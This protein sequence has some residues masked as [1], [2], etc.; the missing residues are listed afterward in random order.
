MMNTVRS[1]VIVKDEN[2]LGPDKSLESVIDN[3]LR[4]KK[5][6]CLLVKGGQ[7]ELQSMETYN[8][9]YASI[10][11]NEVA[12]KADTMM[13][14]AERAVKIQPHLSWVLLMEIEPR[15]TNGHP[16]NMRSDLARHFNYDLKKLLNKISFQ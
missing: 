8:V 3:E 4:K 11:T 13:R 2:I 7:D 12:G 9:L 15:Q 5:F 6:D 1:D 16:Q 10:Y 14:T